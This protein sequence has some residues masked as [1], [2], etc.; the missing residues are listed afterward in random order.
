MLGSALCTICGSSYIPGTFALIG[1]PWP[2]VLKMMNCASPGFG[3]PEAGT[4]ARARRGLIRS[5]VGR[6]VA[7][8]RKPIMPVPNRVDSTAWRRVIILPFLSQADRKRRGRET[9]ND[10]RGLQRVRRGR[11]A[12]S[13][14]LE[15]RFEQVGRGLGARVT[16]RERH[17]DT[18]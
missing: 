2:E 11:A 7:S 10:E 18:H 17:D 1:S 12:L 4:S 15:V 9:C 16:G 13:R 6:P 5:D 3:Q 8:A 14:F